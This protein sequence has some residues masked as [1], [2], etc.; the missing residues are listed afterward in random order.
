M[1][2]TINSQEYRVSVDN[3]SSLC[4]S[5]SSRN[6][7]GRSDVGRDIDDSPGKRLWGAEASSSQPAH[8]PD[9]SQVDG[10]CRWDGEWKLAFFNDAW[11]GVPF[12]ETR[13][14][15]GECV[16]ARELAQRPQFEQTGKAVEVATMGERKQTE[17]SPYFFQNSSMKRV[18]LNIVQGSPGWD[19]K[20]S[21]ASCF[22]LLRS[23]RGHLFVVAAELY[24]RSL[25]VPHAAAAAASVLAR[26]T[27]AVSSFAVSP[28]VEWQ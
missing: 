11:P 1:F 28:T 19:R 16:C 3:Y 24:T 27:S 21:S 15:R 14:W 13:S 4:L 22:C 10:S 26:S 8:I 5:K 6:L 18:A 9:R 17:A 2:H 25:T 7:L 12:E 20:T 23:T